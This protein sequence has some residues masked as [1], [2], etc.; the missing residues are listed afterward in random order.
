VFVLFR[1]HWRG[2]ALS[3]KLRELEVPFLGGGSPFSHDEMSLALFAWE[4]WKRGREVTPRSAQAVVALTGAE[5]M[6]LGAIQAS[7]G[8]APVA[9]PAI[10]HRDP[11]ELRLAEVL[12]RAPGI[13][14]VERSIAR[15]GHPKTTLLSIHQS[16][17]READTVV[18]DTMLARKTFDA[19]GTRPDDE[20]RVWYVGCTRA[21]ERLV[22]LRSP[23]PMVYRL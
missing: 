18:L 6:A 5:W 23:D 12:Y 8:T 13:A 20:H 2:H 17:G 11:R 1:N 22:T 14:Y 15:Y 16:K 21:R 4:S 10:L 19:S 7:R 9:W 3:K